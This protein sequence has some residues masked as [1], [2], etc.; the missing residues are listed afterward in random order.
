MTVDGGA[1]AA[2]RRRERWARRF[3]P[4]EIDLLVVAEAPPSELD[5]YFYFPDVTARDSL[6]RELA[7]L[8]VK[9]APTRENK[10]ELLAALCGAGVFLVDLSLEPIERGEDLSPYVPGLV[11]RVRRLAPRCVILVKATVY[12]AAFEAL[13]SAGL[14]VVNERIPFPG[15]GQQA[16][17]HVAFARALRKCARKGRHV[18]RGQAKTNADG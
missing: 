8:T 6:F 7:A 9:R 14:P 18:A 5:R 11:R 13:R 10:P 3:R 16:N 12:D 15:T 4:A 17:F 1:R 2:R